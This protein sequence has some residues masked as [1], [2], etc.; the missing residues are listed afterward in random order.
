MTAVL[1]DS[2]VILD[3]FSE[4]PKWSDWSSAALAGAAETSRLV[5]NPIVYAEVSI[6]FRRIEDLDLALPRDHF[7]RE[8]IP[9][10]AAFLAG[11]AF[12]HYRKQGGP[13]RSPLPDFFIGAHAAI[14]GYRLL[15]RD[16]RRFR[17][18]FPTLGLIAP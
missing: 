3:V 17:A 1:V 6:H 13:R 4:D 7:I 12:L 15:T 9:F 18:H 8:P 5:I 14:S 10:A 16:A 11:K 2:N